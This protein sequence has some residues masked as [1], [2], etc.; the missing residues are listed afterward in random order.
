MKV[1]FIL[2]DSVR[3]DHLGCYGNRAIHTPNLDRLAAGATVFDEMVAGSFPTGPNRRDILLSK[4]HAPGHAFN[5][6]INIRDDETRVPLTRDE[7]TGMPDAYFDNPNLLRSGDIYLVG[8]AYPQFIPILAHCDN[9]TTRKKVWL[10]YKR[11]GGTGNV[12]VLF[13]GDV[14]TIAGHRQ[15]VREPGLVAYH[16]MEIRNGYFERRMIIR[17]PVDPEAATAQY[18]RSRA[19][20]LAGASKFQT[21]YRPVH[22]GDDRHRRHNGSWG[23]RPAR[24]TRPYGRS[25]GDSRLPGDGRDDRVH[26][27]ELQ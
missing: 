1:I 6:W 15:A 22:G 25:A 9:E 24:R 18:H 7:L 13:D 20:N 3:Q 11:R 19:Y 8:M 23:F 12:R 14:V 4:G 16:Q 10:A 26:R 17:V 2:S 27:A 5:P 21:K